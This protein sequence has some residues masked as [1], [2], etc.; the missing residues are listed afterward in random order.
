MCSMDAF[1]RS[2]SVGLVFVRLGRVYPVF[3]REVFFLVTPGA[4]CRINI[5]GLSTKR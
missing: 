5:S 2:L 3:V 4:R 1:F